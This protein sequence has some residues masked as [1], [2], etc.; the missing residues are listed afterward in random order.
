MT[1]SRKERPTR[2]LMKILIC[3]K[4][5][6]DF[7]H[8]VISEGLDGQAVLG[9]S[10]DY[11][12]N[13]FDEFAVEEA[14]RI[15]ETRTAC[16]VDVLSVGPDRALAVIRRAVGMGADSGIHLRIDA[17]SPL[18]PSSI[19]AWIGRY[20]EKKDYALVLTGCM[21]EDGM[22]GQVGPMLA[23]R[24]GWPCATQVIRL[25]LSGD[26]SAALVE[27]EIEGGCRECLRLRLPAVLT[28]QSGIN[29]PRYPTLSNLLRAHRQEI[30]TLSVRSLG[31]MVVREALLATALRK[32]DRGA[33]LLT[34]TPQEKA[35][36]FF[37]ILT[38]KALI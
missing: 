29:Q 13:R 26:G 5:V 7:E 24:M 36:R 10:F 4:Q 1:T 21:S 19:A 9:G 18:S 30:E 15:K 23:A 20:A 16:R 37:S 12:M 3:V 11:R 28:V 22:H 32:K 2:C 35:A 8:A 33:I 27:R 14:V 38:E 25:R 17:P 31:D 6:P 34:G